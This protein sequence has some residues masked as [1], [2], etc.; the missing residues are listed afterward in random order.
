LE[1]STETLNIFVSP[2]G[3][4]LEYVPIRRFFAKKN[5]GK[6]GNIDFDGGIM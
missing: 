4:F 3:G 1:L 6:T 2:R 5:T